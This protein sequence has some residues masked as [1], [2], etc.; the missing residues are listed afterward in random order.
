MSDDLNL[1]GMLKT[2]MDRVGDEIK[3]RAEE[4][5]K[6][7]VELQDHLARVENELKIDVG[8]FNKFK[9][10]YS[11]TLAEFEARRNALSQIA[12]DARECIACMADASNIPE[13]KKREIRERLDAI[14]VLARG[15][16]PRVQV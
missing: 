13:D 5:K 9:A 6:L 10:N 3:R 11:N 12:N 1:S 16:P 15:I 14:A 2:N 4:I 7:Q 8:G